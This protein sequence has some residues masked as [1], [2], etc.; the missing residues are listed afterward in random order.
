MMKGSMV[1]NS[2]HLEHCLMTSENPWKYQIYGLGVWWGKVSQ[3]TLVCGVKA[4]GTYDMITES[5]V[6]KISMT[7]LFVE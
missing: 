1:F 3:M 2:D 6:W 5:S 4:K 7:F